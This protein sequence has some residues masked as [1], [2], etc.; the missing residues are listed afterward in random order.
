MKKFL[1]KRTLIIIAAFFAVVFL[2]TFIIL[3]LQNNSNGT[4]F[5][6]R[7]SVQNS[8]TL[9]GF[10][11]DVF[12]LGDLEVSTDE[13]GK[14]EFSIEPGEHTVIIQSEG[15]IDYSERLNV[16]SDIE[17]LKILVLPENLATFKGKF[18]ANP[19]YKF[20]NDVL[21]ISNTEISIN[22]DGTFQGA[23]AEGTYTLK[24]TSENFKDIDSIISLSRG[25]NL[26]NEVNL[27]EAGDITGQLQSY[28]KEEAI[29]ELTIISENTK[30][31]QIEIDYQN[32]SFRIKDLDT[33]KMYSLLFR[34]PGYF[35]REYKITI[36]Q[37]RNQIFDLRFV[38]SIQALYTWKN[39]ESRENP[40][41]I[42]SDLDGKNPVQITSGNSTYTNS[43]Y[44]DTE[45]KLIYF[46]SANDD[47]VK[48]SSRRNVGLIYSYDLSTKETK[49]VST[50]TANLG[51]LYPNYRAKK[52]IHYSQDNRSRAYSIHIS[53]LSGDNKVAIYT[54]S[55]EITNFLISDDARYALFSLEV[56]E[57]IIVYRYN[58]SSD[59]YNEIFRG[60][61]INLLDISHNGNKT[62]YYRK[63]TSTG[64]FELVEFIAD[65]N[66]HIII[67]ENFRGNFYQYLK[68]GQ[69]NLIIYATLID[70]RSNIFY[71]NS[72]DNSKTRLISIASDLNILDIYQESGIIYYLTNK[73]LYSVDF[74]KPFANKLV[75]SNVFDYTD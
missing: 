15:Y 52:M 8:L 57:Q 1:T 3:V 51:T 40:N 7:G 64:F 65:R 13:S 18:V 68:N 42:L 33:L 60:S 54:G 35:D 10:K 74:E 55:N 2:V 49:L 66:N 39:P 9:T 62:I 44:L 17:D 27:V 28:L 30:D 31:D 34:A 26:L 25:E 14:F 72:N 29:K 59:F 38:E 12:I 4:K 47:N 71:Y 58:V 70:G 50:N 23:I 56:D 67:E 36:K 22:E 69:S 21:N 61:E 75:T 19:G 5:T 46:Q 37:G 24:F 6:V 32:K 73:G 20:S 63:N 11:P 45:N 16:N 43:R 48:D 41:L 53:D